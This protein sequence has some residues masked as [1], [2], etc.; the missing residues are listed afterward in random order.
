MIPGNKLLLDVGGTFIKCSDGRSIPID[1]A[2]SREDIV[3]SLRLA[4][5]DVT[6]FERICVAIPGP[7]DYENGVFKMKHKFAAVYDEN[8][9]DI[10]SA[11]ADTPSLT[12]MLGYAR[13]GEYAAKFRYIHDVN[14]MLLGEMSFGEG[15]G[16]E[17]VAMVALGT[18]LGF[19]MC[20]GGK[21]LKN[22]FGSPLVSIFNRPF[23]G[24]VLEDYASK[25][26]VLRLYGEALG[27]DVPGG[28]T[29]KQIADKA[30]AGEPA[31]IAA[32]SAMGAIIGESIAPM[33]E[34][35]GIQ[36]LL[37]GGQISRSADLF[38]PAMM[39]KL[40]GVKTLV[41]VCPISDFDNATFNGLKAL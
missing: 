37:L 14:C 27:T 8:F 17:N 28:M 6:R 10:V 21:L 3:S 15:R 29:V 24:G 33:L 16:C 4:V 39:E 7:F 32:F 35:Y 5:G 22:D 2:G 25:R 23:R 38:V 13:S 9:A 30:H 31:S 11:A 40:A 18:G 1:S 26:G 12:E 41:K 20:V 19:S 36:K 34:E